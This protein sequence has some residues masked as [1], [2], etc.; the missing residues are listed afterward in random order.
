MSNNAYA[1]YDIL[2][3]LR[4]GAS[5]PT[6]SWEL[7]LRALA[8]FL[9][10][11]GREPAVRAAVP[12]EHRLA[13]WLDEQRRSAHAGRLSA[14][15]TEQLRAAGLLASPTQGEPTKGGVAWLK[16]ASIAEFLEEEGRLPSLAAPRSAGEKRLAAWLHAQSTGGTRDA[17]VAVA[18]RA[19]LDAAGADRA[20]SL[21]HVG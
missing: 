7:R 18:L 4:E 17:D 15:R 20:P 3:R 16:I 9:A 11:E 12:G 21:A 2:T 14:D 1:Y 6:T 10:L 19:I 5:V 13:L 8:T